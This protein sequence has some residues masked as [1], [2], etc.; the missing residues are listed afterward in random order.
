MDPRKRTV[1]AGYDELSPRYLAW[2]S[3]IED[4]PRERF[5]TELEER[6]SEGAVLELGCGVGLP[7]T[8][9][10]AERFDVVGVDLSE[11]QLKLARTNVPE[12]RFVQG[13]FASLDFDPNSFDAATAYYSITHVP[14]DEHLEL[15][16][17]VCT[18]LKPGG[19]FLASLSAGGSEDWTGDWLGVEMFF[20]GFDG[21][22]NRRLLREAGFDLI[23]DEV[24][25]MR[26]PEGEATFL[27]VLARA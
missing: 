11:Q 16:R 20:S 15:F 1:Q 4:D 12:A 24:V 2:A 6:L 22:T 3:A 26:E 18:W 5:T 14:R 10:L 23:L 17:R 7:S 19:L 8:R 27:W 21:E 25:T 13:D 9:R